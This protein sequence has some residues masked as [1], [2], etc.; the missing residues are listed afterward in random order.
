MAR[1]TLRLPEDLHR[2]LRAV[3]QHRGA[4]LNQLIV[5]ILSEAQAHGRLLDQTQDPLLE[6]VQHVR[7]ALGDL[8]VELDW[9]ALPPHLQPGEDLPDAETLRHSLPELVP[10]L[11]A[12]IIA[13]REDR[14]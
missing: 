3:S 7:R 9:S 8:V 2:R 1:V 12:T 4:S 6:Q 13:D 11:S 14:F 5:A 10:P